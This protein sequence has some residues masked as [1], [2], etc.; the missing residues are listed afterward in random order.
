MLLPQEAAV[1]VHKLH[2]LR[3][4]AWVKVVIAVLEQIVGCVAQSGTASIQPPNRQNP[5]APGQSEAIS[6][7]QRILSHIS[8]VMV[9]QSNLGAENRL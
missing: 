7:L 5:Q 4:L 6:S 2:V 8:S 9:L 1:V 3:Q